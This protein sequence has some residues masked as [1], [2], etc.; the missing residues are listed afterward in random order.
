[1]TVDMVR[2]LTHSQNPPYIWSDATSN[3]YHRN[4]APSEAPF[5]SPNFSSHHHHHQKQETDADADVG[6]RLRVQCV[7]LPSHYLDK[8]GDMP[9]CK[10]YALITFSTKSH[11]EACFVR[12]LGGAASPFPQM[13]STE[14]CP[15]S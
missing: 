10:G 3:A 4:T 12:G 1:M 9:K 6:P 7:T 14:T 8:L 5:V 13:T 11:L 15:S 2:S